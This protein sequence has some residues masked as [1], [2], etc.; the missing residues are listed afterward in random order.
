MRLDIP[1][2]I[3][4]LFNTLTDESEMIFCYIDLNLSV[5]KITKYFS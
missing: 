1:K 5:W 3:K 4:Q 2:Y